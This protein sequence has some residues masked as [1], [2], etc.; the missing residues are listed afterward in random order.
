[1]YRGKTRINRAIE[2]ERFARKFTLLCSPGSRIEWARKQKLSSMLCPSAL[3]LA[4]GNVHPFDAFD[5]TA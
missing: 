3:E 2:D 5:S 1:M 4:L